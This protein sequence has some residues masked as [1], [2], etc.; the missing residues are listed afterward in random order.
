MQISRKIRNTLCTLLGTI[1][2][3]TGC[4]KPKIL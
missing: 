3:S 1:A 4:D 2:V